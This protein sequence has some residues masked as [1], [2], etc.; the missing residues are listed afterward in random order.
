MRPDESST[1]KRAKSNQT[2]LARRAVTL[3]H[4]RW[5]PGMNLI[6]PAG[7]RVVEVAHDWL[8]FDD[9]SGSG[10]GC[11]PSEG[12]P[13]LTDLATLGCFRGLVIEAWGPGFELAVFHNTSG[14]L[15]FVVHVYARTY[16]RP[17]VFLARGST[18][19]EVLVDALEAAP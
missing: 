18:L 5:I 6:R 9:L 16:D 11:G 17:C 19:G 7:W 2:E 15:P 1:S 3:K 12:L 4:W 13:D 10:R 8:G 14:A